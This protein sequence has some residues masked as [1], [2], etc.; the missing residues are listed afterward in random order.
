MCRSCRT[1]ASEGGVQKHPLRRSHS[2]YS[3]SHFHPFFSSFYSFPLFF[4][5][6]HFFNLYC[7]APPRWGRLLL[8]CCFHPSFCCHCSIT[9][10]SSSLLHS[11]PRS[12]FLPS[13]LI[14]DEQC[15]T[16]KLTDE[17]WGSAHFHTSCWF[18]AH[19]LTPSLPLSQPLPVAV[20]KLP[21]LL[22]SLHAD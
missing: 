22:I 16:A 8:H 9:L 6:T 15:P 7:L 13:P 18:Y 1:S 21:L 2:Q 19:S 20:V 10:S 5:I 11:L 12:L 14:S 17:W 3:G 4:L